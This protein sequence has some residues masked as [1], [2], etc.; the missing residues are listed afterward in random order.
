M[1][2]RRHGPVVGKRLGVRLAAR[3]SFRASFKVVRAMAHFFDTLV[4]DETPTARSGSQA[5][6]VVGFQALASP[7]ADPREQPDPGL[8][9]ESLKRLETSGLEIED[10]GATRPGPHLRHRQ[11]A[12]RSS[13][14]P[15][16]LRIARSAVPART[17]R[18]GARGD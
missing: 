6:L 11:P 16:H 9:L 5:T 15:I 18:V 13:R 2:E 10:Q 7:Q 17:Y 8:V 3:P 1:S 12:A 4:L 14:G